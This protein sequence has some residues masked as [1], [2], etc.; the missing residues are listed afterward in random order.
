[1]TWTYR[2]F[3]THLLDNG[4]CIVGFEY[5]G[6]SVNVLTSE[7]LEE[8][9]AVVHDVTE[10]ERVKGIVLVSLKDSFIAGADISEIYEMTD[11]DACKKL[12]TETHAVFGEIEHSKKPWVVAIDGL[13]LGGGLELALVCHWR[14]ATD[15]AVFGLPE[16]K[17]GIIPGLGGTQRLPRLIGLPDALDLITSG[18]NVYAYPALKRGIIDD[19][20]TNQRGERTIDTVDREAFVAVAIERALTLCS[21]RGLKRTQRKQLLQKILGW[22]GVRDLITFKKARRMVKARVKNHYPAPLKA[23]DAVQAGL[24]M[25]VQK[26]CIEAEMPHLLELVVSRLSKDL[27]EVFL[28]TQKTKHQDIGPPFFDPSKHT[29]GVLGAGLMGSQI[30]GEISD[31]GFGVHLKDLEPNFL[32]D[33]MN[34]IMRI[35]KDDVKKRI[36]NKPECE[37]R[38]LRIHPTLSWNDFESTPFV[39]EAIKEVLPWKQKLLEEFEEVATTEAI[40]ATNTSS[41]MISE[42]A[43]NAKHKER[44]VG[45][46]F[47]NPVR[48]MQLVEIVR[49]DSTSAEAV[50]KAY[51]LGS[52]MGKIPLVVRDGPGFLVNRILSRY[53]IEA[54]LLVAE[55]ASITEVDKAAEDFG[56]AIDSGRTMGPLALIDY[57]GIETAIHVLQSLRKL[58]D[59]IAVHALMT[60]MVPQGEKPLTFWNQGKENEDV[61]GLLKNKYAWPQRSVSTEKVI[62]RLILPMR[63]EALRCLEEGIVAQPWQVDL[64]ML[65]GAGFPAFRG[66]L[67]KEMAREGVDQTRADL[68]SLAADYGD[69]FQPCVSFKEADNVLSAYK[70]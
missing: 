41:F 49:S 50:A 45:M 40:F 23:L 70:N 52:L 22:P 64:A 67:L 10:D 9:K 20:V 12:V 62:K 33:G 69:R 60:D 55:G 53:L 13:C 6:R 26:A 4:I 15:N 11:H 68:E 19:L 43:E 16:V 35:K 42:V 44:C 14:V 65:Y 66:G 36:I 59:R 18:R 61:S 28:S 7:A 1:M 39:I 47:F 46:H 38:M 58:G 34:R 51:E 56:M 57:V 17:L 31:R 24:G 8:V 21:K 27:I 37:L 30:A 5:Q 54:V 29:I 25:S 32:C 2:H 3:K 48:K 63:D